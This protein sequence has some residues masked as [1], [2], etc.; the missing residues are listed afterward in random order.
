M[1]R[2]HLIAVVSLG[3]LLIPSALVGIVALV[4]L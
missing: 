1:K 2:E 3:Q 4:R